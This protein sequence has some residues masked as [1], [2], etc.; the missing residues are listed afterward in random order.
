MSLPANFLP[1]IAAGIRALT[2]EETRLQRV[3]CN[4]DPRVLLSLRDVQG[5][6]RRLESTTREEW[7]LGLAMYFAPQDLGVLEKLERRYGN[8]PYLDGPDQSAAFRDLRRA[9]MMV[10][11]VS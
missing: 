8:S 4:G 3:S 5:L 11:G 2:R 6:R 7:E 10:V 9:L 1:T